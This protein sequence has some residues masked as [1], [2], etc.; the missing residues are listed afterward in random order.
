MVVA[1]VAEC[2]PT[3]LVRDVAVLGGWVVKA[4]GIDGF[5]LRY[6]ASEDVM[7]LLV[8]TQGA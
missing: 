6:R 7:L 1:A 3:D 5:A 2:V 4:G 8:R